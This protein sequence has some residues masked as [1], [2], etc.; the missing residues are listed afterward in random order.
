MREVNKKKLNSERCLD[1]ALYLPSLEGGG[2]ER[3]VIAVA[4]GLAER[5]VRVEL[6]LGKT[7]GPYLA[8][9]SPLVSLQEFG[10]DSK[11]G[12]I[13]SLTKYLLKKKPPCIMSALD[14]ANLQLIVAAKLVGFQGRLVV[15]QRAIIGPSYGSIS[16]IHRMAY[17][18][19]IRTL[20]PLADLVIS[21]SRAAAK[22]LKDNFGIS[23]DRIVTIQNQVDIERVTRFSEV[24]LDDK[25]FP[26]DDSP[27]IIS[28]GSLTPRKDMETLIKALA[29]V[30]KTHNVKLVVLGEGPER[31]K[32]QRLINK[33]GLRTAV[34]LLGFDAN[35]YKWMKNAKVL[36]SA[37]RAEGFPNVIVEALSL[38]IKV[39]ATDCPGD[40]ADILGNGRWG[41]LVPVSDIEALAKAMSESLEEA[42]NKDGK[43]RACDFEPEKNINAYE[44]ALL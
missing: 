5:G 40:T 22:E 14:L 28:V 9:V 13:V 41:R 37:S 43:Q 19:A 31:A 7:I 34:F 2:A 44:Q 36:V 35:P 42:P 3:A 15:S 10:T 32:L 21:N 18:V 11:I 27:T 16:L 1:L 33:L 38:G 29:Q 23:S 8:E 24:A 39:V 17:L 26:E 30:R 25:W 4:N 12:C 20:Y 6:I